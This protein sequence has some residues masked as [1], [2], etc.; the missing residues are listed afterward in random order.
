MVLESKKSR[1]NTR[2]NC[3]FTLIEL[4]VVMAIISLLLAILLPALSKIRQLTRRTVC[5]SNLR[6]I[7]SA[8]HI[9]LEDYNG[10]FYKHANADV[11]YGGWKGTYFP[12]YKRPLN[13][14]LG[15]QEL[16]QSESEAK[17]FYCP[18]DDIGTG[19]SFYSLIGT[20]YKTNMLL[21]GDVVVAGLPS[22]TLR[23]AINT[24][25]GHLNFY[26]VAEPSQL[27]MV[28]DY[29]WQTQWLPSPYP[30]GTPWHGR[31]CHFNMAFLDGHVEFIKIYKGLHIT[32]EYRVI[33][34]EDLY[35]LAHQEQVWEPCPKCD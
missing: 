5:Q 7:A 16:P 27:L 13:E 29:P 6:Q 35:G 34:F 8:W 19:E 26:Q 4:L 1:L 25:L 2:G 24:K 12:N 15:V 11:L 3:G 23:D 30:F 10:K 9:Y 28:G 32:D 31:C 21:I 33:P 14:Y 17:V 22:S 20:S 18:D